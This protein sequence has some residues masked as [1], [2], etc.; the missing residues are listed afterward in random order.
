MDSVLG[1]EIDDLLILL[2]GKLTFCYDRIDAF[3]SPRS[4]LRRSA[5]GNNIPLMTV[6][7]NVLME[8]DVLIFCPFVTFFRFQCEMISKK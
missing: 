5:I 3:F 2:S 4:N 8:E 6:L 1:N 7:C